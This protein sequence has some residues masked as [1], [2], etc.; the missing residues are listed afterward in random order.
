MKTL[1]LMYSTDARVKKQRFA[2][3]IHVEVDGQKQKG[4]GNLSPGLYELFATRRRV[5]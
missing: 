2:E 4:R 5:A 1:E 3:N